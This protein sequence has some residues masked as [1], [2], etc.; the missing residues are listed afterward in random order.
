MGEIKSRSFI[1]SFIELTKSRVE[2]IF[3]FTWSAALGSL[4]AGSGFPPIKS[5]I[6]GMVSALFLTLAVYIYNDIIDREMD[7]S[8]NYIRKQTERPLAHGEIP[9]NH[10]Y[11]FVVLSSIIGLATAWTI[12]IFVTLL[13]GTAVQNTYSPIILFTAILSWFFTFLIFPLISDTLDLEE[14]KLYGV[15][16]IAMVYSW[17]QILNMYMAAPILVI[18]SSIIAY[19][20]LGINLISTGL[21]SLIGFILLIKAR[22]MPD[23]YDETAVRNLRKFTYG[24][25][26]VLNIL[27]LV[28]TINLR[29]ITSFL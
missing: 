27:I 12:N 21:L 3:V 9:V 7:A 15:K 29:L 23:E 13:G 10:A 14:D 22:R 8:S 18:A 28:G 20:F 26:M 5:T 4:I 19:Y 1:N 2:I 16:T 11:A 6:L 17:D 24:F 25:F